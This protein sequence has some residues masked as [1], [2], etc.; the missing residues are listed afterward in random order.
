M[1]NSTFN[2]RVRKGYCYL[3]RM[4]VARLHNS[5][6]ALL[7]QIAKNYI[8]NRRKIAKIAAIIGLHAI[9]LLLMPN[10]LGFGRFYNKQRDRRYYGINACAGFSPS[11]K[12]LWHLS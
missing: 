6:I 11:V 10:P 7:R 9:I 3:A 2:K 5:I 12:Y 4:A 1:Y 8:K